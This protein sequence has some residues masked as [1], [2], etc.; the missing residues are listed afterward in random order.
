[1]PK[2]KNSFKSVSDKLFAELNNLREGKVS[3][4]HAKKTVAEVALFLTVQLEIV[5]TLE[6]TLKT[7]QKLERKLLK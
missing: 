6:K 7:E 3:L 5:K 4:E 1:M 2:P